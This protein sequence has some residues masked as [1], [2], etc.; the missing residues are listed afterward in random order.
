M[1]GTYVKCRSVSFRSSLA[2]MRHWWH[3]YSLFAGGVKTG[4]GFYGYPN[5]AYQDPAWRHGDVNDEFGDVL[6]EGVVR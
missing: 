5:P 4:R 6:G 1:E 3:G 2:N